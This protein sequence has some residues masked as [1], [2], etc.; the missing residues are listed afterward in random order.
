MYE[1]GV[2]VPFIAMGPGIKAGAINPLT[3]VTLLDMFPTFMAMAGT[4]DRSL[5]LDGCDILPLLFGEEKSARFTDGSRRDTLL[6]HHPMDNKSFSVI[7]RGDWKLIKNTGP[8]LTDAPALQL[9]RLVNDDGSF[10][11]LSEKHNLVDQHPE[12]A[13]RMLGEL[14]DWMAQHDARVPYL[15]PLSE[16]PLP[17]QDKVTSVTDCGSDKTRIWA[18]F[19][20]KGKAKVEKAFLVYTLNGGTELKSHPPRLEEWFHAPAELKN[21]RVEADAAPGMT[22]AV[23]C[24]VDENNFLIYSDSVPP[25]GRECRI[26]GPVSTFLEDGFAYR[27]GLLALIREGH[28]ARTRLNKKG[29]E[30]GK[31]AKA[32]T[33]ARAVA[34]EPVEEKAYAAAIRN[35]RHAIRDFDGQDAA[36]SHVDLNR[37]P[38]GKW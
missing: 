38:L 30:T 16:K 21:G 7:C 24:L 5:D 6:F 34:K 19:E 15:N 37:L 12:I 8:H 25:V 22:H 4:D 32:L 26:D 13:N 27:P 14:T 33:A 17:G 3:P 11:D 35:L 2:R 29:I 23:F 18:E 20:T 28:R 10:G 9:F 1:G 36:A 31:L